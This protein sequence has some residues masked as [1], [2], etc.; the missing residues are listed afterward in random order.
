M[1]HLV[2]FTSVV[3]AS[4]VFGVTRYSL[5]MVIAFPAVIVIFALLT[6]FFI[7]HNSEVKESHSEKGKGRG[8]KRLMLIF[9]PMALGA[10]S[11]LVSALQEGWNIG[12]TIGV[13]VFIVLSLLIGYE[14]IRRNRNVYPSERPK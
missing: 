9:V 10:I 3:I 12:D 4:A 13:C 14:A 1:L 5:R 8:R 11:A 6:Y 2:L 7:W